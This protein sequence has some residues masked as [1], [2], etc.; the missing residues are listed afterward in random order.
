MSPRLIR[1][2]IIG[3]VLIDLAFIAY[4]WVMQNWVHKVSEIL[5]GLMYGN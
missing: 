1:L 3:Q 4:I 2:L 5:E